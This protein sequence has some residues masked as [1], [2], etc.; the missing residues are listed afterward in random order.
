VSDIRALIAGRAIEVSD[1]CYLERVNLPELELEERL[2][3]V[4]THFALSDTA[5][6]KRF[7]QKVNAIE[8]PVR[9]HQDDD[10]RSEFCKIAQALQKKA[11]VMFCSPGPLLWCVKLHGVLSVCVIMMCNLWQGVSFYKAKLPRWL[12]VRVKRSPLRWPYV[13]P[14][15]LEQR[16]TLLQ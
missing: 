15:L 6:V 7:V 3:A 4:L 14:L 1:G 12:Q 10:L 16:F 5:A 2:R 13:L 9:E 11:F 8:Q